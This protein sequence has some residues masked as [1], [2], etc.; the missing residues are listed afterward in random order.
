[1]SKRADWQSDQDFGREAAALW[2]AVSGLAATKFSLVAA[3]IETL[4]EGK[5]MGEPP[6]TK[7]IRPSSSRRLRRPTLKIT[8]S[9]TI[10]IAVA[11]GAANLLGQATSSAAGRL[12]ATPVAQAKCSATGTANQAVVDLNTH[13]SFARLRTVCIGTLHRTGVIEAGALF[14]FKMSAPPEMP[15]PRSFASTSTP[16]PYAI[17]PHCRSRLD[18]RWTR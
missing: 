3:A 8:L 10:V 11:L 14:V 13:R 15:A 9:F 18:I 4:T 17:D 1:M 2:L 6:A 7:A 5:N 16:T 12:A